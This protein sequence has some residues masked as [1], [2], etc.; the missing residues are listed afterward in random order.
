MQNRT[1][2]EPGARPTTMPFRKGGTKTPAH[3]GTTRG[4]PGL[5]K[6]LKRK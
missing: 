1:I 3:T 4:K 5:V 2:S 6:S